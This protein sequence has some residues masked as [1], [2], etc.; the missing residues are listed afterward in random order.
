MVWLPWLIPGMCH[1]GSVFVGS[2][3]DARYSPLPAAVAQAE[4]AFATKAN[5]AL[6]VFPGAEPQRLTARLLAWLA[7][8]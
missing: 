8:Q 1:A 3:L 5:P 4:Y 2:P 6:E 7:R